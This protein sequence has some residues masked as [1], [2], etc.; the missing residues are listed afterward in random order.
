MLPRISWTC[1]VV[2][3]ILGCGASYFSHWWSTW[4]LCLANIKRYFNLNNGLVKIQTSKPVGFMQSCSRWL[5]L[6]W[7]AEFHAVLHLV[8][9]ACHPHA[10]VV[11]MRMLSAHTCHLHVHIICMSS[12][13][14]HVIRTSSAALL[15]V[16]VDLNYL[17][18]L[19]GSGYWMEFVTTMLS[20]FISGS[21]KWFV[22]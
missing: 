13:H 6:A 9:C 21:Y 17:S 18:T 5:P 3:V 11:Y 22:R 4:C 8:S 10:D 2:C 19:T 1:C 15:M 14:A 20:Y 16:S 12:T 7:V